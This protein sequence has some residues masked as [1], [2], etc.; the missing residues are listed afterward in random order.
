M[1]SWN[2]LTLSDL[3]LEHGVARVIGKGKKERFVPI[4]KTALKW[5]L[6]YIRGVR[7]FM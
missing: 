7:P 5:L 1:G 2:C 3:D 4:G 6:S